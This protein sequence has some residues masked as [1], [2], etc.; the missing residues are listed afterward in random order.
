MNQETFRSILSIGETVAV[1]FK[2]CGN[3][4]EHDVYESVCSFLNRFGGDIF[5]GVLDDGTVIGVPEKAATDMIKNFISVISNDSVFHPTVYLVP[6]LIKLEGRTVIHVHVPPSSEVHSYKRVIY[7]R[8]DDA[9]VKVTATGAIAAMYIRKQNVFTEKKIYPYAELADLRLDLL[10]RVRQAAVNHAM[11]RHPWQ[12]MDDMELLKSAGLYGTDAA[13]GEKG[14]NLAAIL[15]LGKDEVIQNVCPSYETDA[16]VRKVNLD[17]YDDRETVRTNL[18]ESYEFVSSYMAKFVIMQDKMH[19]ENANR[20]AKDGL[21][22]PDNLEPVSKNPVIATFFRNIGRADRLGS[23]VRNLFKYSRFYSGGDPKLREGDIFRIVVPLDE[24]Y[25]YDYDLGRNG[26]VN[27]AAGNN[28]DI[29]YTLQ[30]HSIDNLNVNPVQNELVGTHDATQDTTHDATQDTTQDE[31]K[32]RIIEYCHIPR[33][34]KEIAAS[35]DLR[36]NRVSQKDI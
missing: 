27:D 13:T 28:S 14:F 32:K 12:D 33:S 9:D 18:I 30:D 5:M 11:G 29:R 22:T 26:V 35:W 16:L 4:I 1:E 7:D 17:R 2:R 25:S 6:E 15:L 10:P 8:V 24:S 3:G 21:I 20:A 36:M 34:K 23:G 31:L 19:T